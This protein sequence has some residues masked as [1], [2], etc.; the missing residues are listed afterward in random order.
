MRASTGGAEVSA[1]CVDPAKA[2]Q[3]PIRLDR[4]EKQA[5]RM[6]PKQASDGGQATMRHVQGCYSISRFL[7]CWIVYVRPSRPAGMGVHSGSLTPMLKTP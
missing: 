5:R 6:R 3:S 2:R 4:G 1:L 7:G